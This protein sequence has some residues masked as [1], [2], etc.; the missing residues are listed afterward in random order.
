M[1][2][3]EFFVLAVCCT[4]RLAHA[5]GVAPDLHQLLNADCAARP[6][7]PSS[8]DPVQRCVWAQGTNATQL[9]IYYLH[10]VAITAVKGDF[11]GADHL[12]NISGGAM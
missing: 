12:L 9:Q 4:T 5:G 11:E 1:M 10:P 8:P 2:R 7:Q 3:S 6:Q